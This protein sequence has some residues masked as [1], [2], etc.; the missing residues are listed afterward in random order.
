MNL[1]HNMTTKL[2]LN[3]ESFLKDFDYDNC[4]NIYE[5]FFSNYFYEIGNFIIKKQ[6]K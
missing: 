5:S 6:F 1:F 3:M 4:P 2:F